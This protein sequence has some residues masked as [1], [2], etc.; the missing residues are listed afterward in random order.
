M[1]L[2]V[3]KT[4]RDFLHHLQ[5]SW[6][7][8]LLII[9]LSVALVSLIYTQTAYRVPQE[10]RIDIYIQS[11]TATQEAV[12]AFIKPIWEQAVPEQESV[13]AMTLM[14]PGGENDYYANMQLMTY[15]AAA[16]G[17]I[18][19]LPSQTFKQY[20]SQ[21]AFVDL[22]PYIEKGAINT[23]GLDLLL[24]KVVEVELRPD[25][26][27]VALGEARQFGIPAASLYGFATKMQIDNRDLVLAL[28]VNSR[29]EE[30]G[31]RFLNAF[32]QSTRVE[33]PEYFK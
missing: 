4:K 17:D 10:K 15:V 22:G 12:N 9:G 1:K 23:E 26:S 11:A 6:Y 33:I 19:I 29:N 31:V 21:G 24:G 13:T 8:Y 27:A 5:Y 7:L 25:G 32:I 18:Y 3:K 28:A 16:E 14:A 2:T 20:A 30:P